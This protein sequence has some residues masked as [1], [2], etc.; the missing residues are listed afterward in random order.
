MSSPSSDS[1]IQAYLDDLLAASRG[2]RP[3][4]VREL[5]AEAEAHLYDDSAALVAAGMPE[6][7]S[8]AEAVAQI[9]STRQARGRGP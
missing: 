2:M 1:P 6:H 5:L 4:E 3:R 8:E 9:R 7:Q